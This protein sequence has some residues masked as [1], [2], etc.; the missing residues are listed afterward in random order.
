MQV[1]PADLTDPTQLRA[2]ED[3]CHD[4]EAPID[5]LVN[6]AGF[7]TFGAFHTLDVEGENREIQLNAVA[8]VRLYARACRARDERLRGRAGILNVSSPA[9]ACFGLDEPPRSKTKYSVTFTGKSA[10]SEPQRNRIGHGAVPGFHAHGFPVG[11]RRPG[12]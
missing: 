9:P 4:A 5:V 12:R 3:R 10:M 7:G 2:V 1:L 6:N 8:L 11:R